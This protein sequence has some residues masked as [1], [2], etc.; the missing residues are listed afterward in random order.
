MFSGLHFTGSTPVFK[1]I[2][3]SVSSNLDRYRSYPRI[4]G[5]TGGKNMHFVH[6]SADPTNVIHQTIRAA[7]ENQG[8]PKNKNTRPLHTTQ[9]MHVCNVSRV[10]SFFDLY[11]CRTKMLRMLPGVCS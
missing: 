5:E 8:N 3:K 2:W 9:S 4:V 1:S 10:C 6:S 7:F 11:Y